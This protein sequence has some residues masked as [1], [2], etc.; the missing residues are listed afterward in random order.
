MA[1]KKQKVKRIKSMLSKVEE[2]KEKSYRNASA[3]A[4]AASMPKRGLRLP[5]SKSLNGSSFE[6]ALSET[7]GFC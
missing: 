6:R 7:H 5:S 3:S 2:G 4:A 1:K